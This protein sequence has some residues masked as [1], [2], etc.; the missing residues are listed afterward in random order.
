[1]NAVRSCMQ[2]IIVYYIIIVVIYKFEC[3][4]VQ[5]NFS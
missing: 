3:E 1:M 2:D 5:L 4:E